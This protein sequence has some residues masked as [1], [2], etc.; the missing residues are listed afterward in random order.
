[1]YMAMFAFWK[2][3]VEVFRL[4]PKRAQ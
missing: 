3:K 2:L 1:V 4:D